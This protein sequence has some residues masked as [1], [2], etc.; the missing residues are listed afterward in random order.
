MKEESQLP[1]KK[2]HRVLP[3][4]WFVLASLYT[5]SPLDLIPDIFPVIGWLDDFSFLSAAVLHLFQQYYEPTNKLLK[6]ILKYLKWI[7]LFFG[8]LLILLF[9]IL[10]Y[11]IFLNN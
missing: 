7:L 10:G 11:L 6:Q 4:I 8:I 9:S 1:V 2:K 3:W 5:F